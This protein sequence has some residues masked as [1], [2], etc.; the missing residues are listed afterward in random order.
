MNAQEAA[1]LL[2]MYAGAWPKP[3]LTEEQAGVWVHHLRGVDAE[4][5]R[6]AMHELVTED[7]FP[8]R[9][10]RFLGR[11]DDV[12]RRLERALPPGEEQVPRVCALCGG[13]GWAPADQEHPGYECYERCRCFRRRDHQSGCTCGRC[14]YPVETYRVMQGGNRPR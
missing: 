5:G 13:T 14:Y 11:C 3:P 7:E 1:G 8:P 12:R 6:Q 2:T 4:V 9:V 10:A